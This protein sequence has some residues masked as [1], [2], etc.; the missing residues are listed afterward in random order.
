M[1]SID[2]ARKLFTVIDITT[3][4][5]KLTSI[6][7]HLGIELKSSGKLNFIDAVLFKD[8][9]FPLIVYNSHRDFL[10]QRFTIAHEIGHYVMPH[11]SG[12]FSCSCNMEDLEEEREANQFAA[13]LLMPEV[14]FRNK[15]LEYDENPVHRIEHLSSIFE[16]SSSAVKIRIDRLRLR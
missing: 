1:K 4:P 14:I 7:K 10:R 3:P 13:E 5:V 2:Y 12:I 9:K 6:L 8:E 11:K 16:V 15:W